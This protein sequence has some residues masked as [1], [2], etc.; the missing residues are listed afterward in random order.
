MINYDIKISLDVEFV[1]NSE[2]LDVGIAVNDVT[3]FRDRYPAQRNTFLINTQLTRGQ[4]QLSIEFQNKPYHM[5]SPENDIAVLIHSVKFQNIDADFKDFSY[6]KPIYP[7]QWLTEQQS[8]GINP[9]PVI[10]ANYL[11]WDGR[12]FLDFS[13]PI[14]RWIHQRLDLGWL[15]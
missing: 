9:S 3:F 10:I 6:Y 4:H 15:I 11:G 14:Y 1:T 12:W 8:L 13:T 2:P 7:A 5:C